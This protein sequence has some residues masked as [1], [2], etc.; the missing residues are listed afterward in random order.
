MNSGSL[1]KILFNLVEERCVL[2]ATLR[3]TGVI[4]NDKEST[5]RHGGFADIFR[6][7]YQGEEV[8]LKRLRAFS[9][10]ATRDALM[11]STSLLYQGME[12]SYYN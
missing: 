4:W 8:A 11:V 2:P 1:R 3:V 7:I 9:G 5:G 10:N 6:G 12:S